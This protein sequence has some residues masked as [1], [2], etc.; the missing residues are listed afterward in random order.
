MWSLSNPCEW[1]IAGAQK[2]TCIEV[3]H[4]RRID[5]DRIS[6]EYGLETVPVSINGRDGELASSVCNHKRKPRR[7]RNKGYVPHRQITLCAPQWYSSL[8]KRVQTSQTS[9]YHSTYDGYSLTM[10]VAHFPLP[11]RAH[12]HQTTQEQKTRRTLPDTR[13]KENV[14]VPKREP[15]TSRPRR[16]VPEQGS[17][18]SSPVGSCTCLRCCSWG[19]NQASVRGR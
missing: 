13:R 6:I 4:Q 1:L 2:R 18:G 3:S 9:R 14:T 7:R 5:A 11:G 19:P 10:R 8:P 17:N 15:N 12:P 16:H